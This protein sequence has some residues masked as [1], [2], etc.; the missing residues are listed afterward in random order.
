MDILSSNS[1]ALILNAMVCIYMTG[2]IGIIHFV[3]YPSF[4]LVDRMRFL[5]FHTAH[6]KALS[7]LAGV[8]MCVELGS[9]LWLV[10]SHPT[11]WLIGF[12]GG[13][14]LL[15]WAVTFFWSVPAHNQLTTGF[16]EKAW[17]SLMRSNRL[18]TI[19]WGGRSIGF[20]IFF[21]TQ[22]RA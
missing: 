10:L 19:V 22:N 13:A 11:H 20:L 9:A 2:L 16:Q 14:V 1:P 7:Y 4:P 18:R 8:P 5:D 15:L 12:N 3:H 6:S 17:L 21:L